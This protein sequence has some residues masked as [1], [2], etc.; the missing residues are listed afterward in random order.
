MRAW[1]TVVRS[2]F[3]EWKEGICHF[4][5]IFGHGAVLRESFVYAAQNKNVAVKPKAETV[6]HC[7]QV[8]I[9]CPFINKYSRVCD[10]LLHIQDL[11][12]HKFVSDAA[13]CA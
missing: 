10:L 4:F 9:Y 5:T 3:Y 2:Q 11:T 8:E 13:S 1:K 6:P 7:L 12:L